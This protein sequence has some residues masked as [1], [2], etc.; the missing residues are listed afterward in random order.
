M[1]YDWGE[2]KK[3]SVLTGSVRLLRGTLGVKGRKKGAGKEN[4]E[5]EDIAQQMRSVITPLHFH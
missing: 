4:L 1:R 2:G 5:K 3:I